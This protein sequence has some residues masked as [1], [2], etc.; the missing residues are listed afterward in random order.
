MVYL[1]NSTNQ[2]EVW[3]PRNDGFGFIHTGSSHSYQEGFE[4]G[5]DY[6]KSLLATT[7][8]T[9]NGNYH[10]NDGWSDVTVNVPQ[11]GSTAK[12]EEKNVVVSA[13]TTNVSPSIGYDGMSAVTIDASDYAQTNY[14]NGFDDGYTDGY[15]SGASEGYDSGYT[16]GHTDGVNEEKAK[17]SA[18]T[19]TANTAVTISDGGYSAITVNVP[20]TGSSIPLSSITIIENTAITETE[21][22]YSAITVNVPQTGHTDQELEDAYNSGHTDGVSEEKAK[23][24]AVTFTA[25]TAVTLS[26]GSYSSVTVN[27]PQ[28]GYTQEDLDN[29]YASG[30]TIGE[31]TIIATFSSMTATTNGQYGSSA[32]PLSS[33]TVNVPQSS[34]EPNKSFTATTNGNYTITPSSASTSVNETYNDSTYTISINFNGYPQEGNFSVLDIKDYSNLANGY[35][36][37]YY[38][39]GFPFSQSVGW[40]GGTIFTEARTATLLRL[41]ITSANEN[42]GWEKCSD[43]LEAYDVMSAVSLTVNV[44]SSV[45]KYVEYIETDGSEIMFDLDTMLTSLD[46]VVYF[47]FMPLSGNAQYDGWYPFVDAENFGLRTC[48]GGYQTNTHY[49]YK[50]GNYNYYNNWSS[51]PVFN[52]GTKYEC[53]FTSTGSSVNNTAT[54]YQASSIGTPSNIHLNGWD[55][56]GD[57]SRCPIARYYGF[58]IMSG[59]TVVSDFRPCLDSNNVPCF[60]EEVS[61]TYIYASGSG[62][63]ISGPT[64]DYASG[65]TDGYASGYTDGYASGFTDGF[66]SGLTFDYAS[67]FTDGYASGFTDGSSAFLSAITITANTVINAN[68]G[69]YSAITVNVPQ[70]GASGDLRYF[71]EGTYE[72]WPDTFSIPSGTKYIR[73]YCFAGY[74]LNDIIVPNS[75]T[76]MGEYAFYKSSIHLFKKANGCVIE[77]IP[78]YAF[79]DCAN[80]DADDW[81]IFDD[82]LTIGN[83]AFQNCNSS[84]FTTVSA[85]CVTTIGNYAFRNC[86]GLTEVMFGGNINNIKTRAFNGCTSLSKIYMLSATAPSL[87][88]NPFDGIPQ[89]GTFHYKSGSDY[90]SIQ[91]RTEF[92]GWTFVGDL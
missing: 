58:K 9:E 1:D 82:V 35:I 42:F 52:S 21:K 57:I 54:T 80:L 32:H 44:T 37:V 26:D 4:D 89:T 51:G 56:D 19:F 39:N 5:R 65:Y 30:E 16:S 33:I 83:Y 81:P 18:T 36:N 55:D 8:F 75:V 90:S 61:Q 79:A 85:C 7:A 76:G 12:L 71:I 63:P 77:N 47:D 11:T 10:R 29:A 17:L 22:A 45:P 70:T 14:E 40:S 38:L 60:Y 24:S 27:V 88:I 31:N 20:Q 67:G 74:S 62:T 50:F 48:W 28:T 66:A 34:I 23:M 64:F 73:P 78:D 69:G 91:S 53:V 15:S 13:D 6:Q 72:D 86:T 25:N 68:Q 92:S 59:N 41:R 87:G 3:I 49:G 43:Y 46:E 84:N 2:Q